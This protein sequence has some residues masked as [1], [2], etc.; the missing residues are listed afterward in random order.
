MMLELLILAVLCSSM[1]GMY[2]Y[3]YIHTL[4]KPIVILIFFKFLLSGRLVQVSGNEET[5][6]NDVVILW[7]TSEVGF[8]NW[9]IISSTGEPLTSFFLNSITVKVNMTQ[10]FSLVAQ[11]TFTNGSFINATVTIVRPINLNGGMIRCS[12]DTLTLNI[13]ANTGKFL[14][15][16]IGK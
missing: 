5:C 11:V 10:E 3:M 16:G 7:C 1:Q 2:R 8:L 12:Q 4:I 14:V 9:K 6:S 13:P 15:A